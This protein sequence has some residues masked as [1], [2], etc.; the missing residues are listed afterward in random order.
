M[1]HHN[2]KQS[3]YDVWYVLKTAIVV[4]PSVSC[5]SYVLYKR[6]LESIAFHTPCSLPPLLPCSL[7]ELNEDQLTTQ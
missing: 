3:P 2:E 6:R 7:P 5:N 1:V 4:N